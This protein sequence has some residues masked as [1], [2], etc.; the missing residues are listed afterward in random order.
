MLLHLGER[1]SLLTIL[2][3]EGD[4]TTLRIVAELR[5]RLAPSE[6]E[7]QE[8]GIENMDGKLGWLREP[9]AEPREVEIGR[10]ARDIIQATLKRLSDAGKLHENHLSLYGKFVEDEEEGN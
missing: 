1:F 3:R 6:A 7:H 8:F 10:K 9:D 2:P 5:Q 4:I